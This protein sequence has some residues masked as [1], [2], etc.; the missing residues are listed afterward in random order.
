MIIR[1][2]WLLISFSRPI[3]LPDPSLWW[4]AWLLASS[5]KIFSTSGTSPPASN[6]WWY[7]SGSL[8]FAQKVSMSSMQVNL[9]CV[10]MLSYRPT[11]YKR[12]I[13]M[14]LRTI[15]IK[16]CKTSPEKLILYKGKSMVSV[17]FLV[18]VHIQLAFNFSP[19]FF[20][21]FHVIFF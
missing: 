14:N 13:K 2:C 3:C 7:I 12:C 10:I 8:T 20:F 19:I 1:G 4:L 5:S 6:I 17:P 9:P 11:I 21:Q 18:V 15:L 16:G